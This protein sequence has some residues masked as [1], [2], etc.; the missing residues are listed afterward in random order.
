MTEATAASPQ[1]L[2]DDAGPQLADP[3]P[4]SIITNLSLGNAL[5]SP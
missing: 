4:P 1:P 2:D 3:K 5:D